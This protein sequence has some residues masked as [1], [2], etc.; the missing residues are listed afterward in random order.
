MP[1]Y[2]LSMFEGDGGAFEQSFGRTFATALSELPA[3]LP[4]MKEVSLPGFERDGV[5]TAAPPLRPTVLS[6]AGAITLRAE[7]ALRTGLPD[8]ARTLLKEASRSASGSAQIEALLALMA[9]F[10]G[11][12]AR[13]LEHWERAITLEDREGW[14]YFELA[15]RRREDGAPAEHIDRLLRQAIDGDPSHADARVALAAR[16]TDAGFAPA[17]I[18]LLEEAARIE[19]SRSSTWYALAFAL[20]KA[21]RRTEAL[22]AAV[23][24]ART[25]TSPPE[26]TMA[27]ALRDSLKHN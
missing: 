27:A 21:G 15:M 5:R 25:A 24:A 1:A 7:L 12:R 20:D 8:L 14:M 19:P 22:A 2:L 9:T 3:Y 26:E 11:D 16:L 18:T 13:A 10:D 23:K 17:A 4:K 6:K